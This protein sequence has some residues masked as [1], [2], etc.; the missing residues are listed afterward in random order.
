[1]E[2]HGMEREVEHILSFTL[3]AAGRPAAEVFSASYS[4][5]AQLCCSIVHVKTV[6]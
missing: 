1:M 3:A 4:K 5:E 6:K 2:L